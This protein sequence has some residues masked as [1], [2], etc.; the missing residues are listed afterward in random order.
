MARGVRRAASDSAEEISR[1]MNLPPVVPPE[2]SNLTDE[3]LAMFNQL[4]TAR[5]EWHEYDLVFVVRLAKLEIKVREMWDR[6]LEADFVDKQR[7]RESAELLAFCRL[8]NQQSQIITKLK[9][10]DR[11]GVR[12]STLNK[13]SPLPKFKVSDFDSLIKKP[14]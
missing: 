11:G 7:G 6:C 14:A 13:K 1:R 5:D 9:L 4:V 10:N 12:G 8:I 2:G 3:E